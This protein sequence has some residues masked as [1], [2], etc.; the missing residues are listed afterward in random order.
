L[1]FDEVTDLLLAP[2]THGVHSD[3]PESSTERAHKTALLLAVEFTVL[4]W[5]VRPQVR[6]FY[7]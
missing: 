3:S 5:S 4:K 6:A 1:I 2:F 7:F